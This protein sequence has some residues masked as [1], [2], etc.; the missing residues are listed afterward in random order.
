MLL[1]SPFR[2]LSIAQRARSAHSVRA[3]ANPNSVSCRTPRPDSR[4]CASFTVKS[5]PSVKPIFLIQVFTTESESTVSSRS[6]LEA[7]LCVSF[8]RLNRVASCWPHCRTSAERA[9]ANTSVYS[10]S[11]SRRLR[12]ISGP[13]EEARRRPDCKSEHAVLCDPGTERSGDRDG[14]RDVAPRVP[15]MPDVLGTLNCANASSMPS[16]ATCCLLCASSAAT[17]VRVRAGRCGLGLLCR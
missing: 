6:R 1:L 14:D 5:L 12:R 17:T 15:V 7:F 2:S 11:I 10:A 4:I 8:R 16:T 9:E 13:S 3:M